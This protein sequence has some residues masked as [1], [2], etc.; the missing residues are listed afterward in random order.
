MINNNVTHFILFAGNNQTNTREIYVIPLS[1]SNPESRAQCGSY[2]AWEELPEIN[3]K[4]RKRSQIINPSVINHHNTEGQKCLF[5]SR[6][7]KVGVNAP[8]CCAFGIAEEHLFE[9]FFDDLLS[10][11]DSCICSLSTLADILPKL[12][13]HNQTTGSNSFSNIEGY[14]LNLWFIFE[15]KI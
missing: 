7:H 13:P 6:R 9:H 14:V 15:R 8:K 12:A 3:K 11:T 4:T 5:C 10:Q 2:P 1:Y